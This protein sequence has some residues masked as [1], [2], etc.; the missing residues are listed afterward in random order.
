[1]EHMT[2]DGL[3]ILVV[4]DSSMAVDVTVKLLRG[5]GHAAEGL[6]GSQGALERILELQPDVVVSDIMMPGINGF[7]LC[8]MIRSEKALANV[9][10]VMA[11]AKAY[12]PDQNKA[13]RMGADGYI[14][15]PFTIAK[16]D[17]I[18]QSLGAM[19]LPAWGVRGT[20]PMP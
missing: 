4:D 10:V 11:S 1:M 2:A 20:L 5:A 13:K 14:V 3:K 8:S 9:R 19:K 6:L 7:E 16:F 18:M 17:S 12:E 15:K